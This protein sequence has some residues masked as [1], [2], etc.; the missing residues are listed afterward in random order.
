LLK[1]KGGNRVILTIVNDATRYPEA[2]ALKSC[3][4]ESV[5]NALL[6]LCSR[7][8]IPKVILTDQGSNFT[9]QLMKDL[10]AVLKLKGVT[11]SPYHPQ[12]NG[13]T[14]RFNGKKLCSKEESEWDTPL[15]YALFAYR[16][17]PH[18]EMG[19]SP[20]EVLYGR[21]VRG[22]TQVIKEFMAGE[23]EIQMSVI[24]HVARIREKLKDIT[25]QVHD[26]LSRRKHFVKQWYDKS[27]TDRRFYPGDEVLVLL[28][29]D[30]SRMLVQ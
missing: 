9:S 20:F 25:L 18:E 15:P 22:P 24:E 8:G 1:Q 26:N 29:S 17:V 12:A 28:P 27:V 19:F 3:D 7:V 14:E 4:A 2:F 21:P 6:Q 5:A 11:T 16:E 10:I 13:K 30:T 23:E